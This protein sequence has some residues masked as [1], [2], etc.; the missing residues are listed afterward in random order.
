[1]NLPNPKYTIDL[2]YGS[3]EGKSQFKATSP[4][5][6][7]ISVLAA[8]NFEA[9]ERYRELVNEYEKN[10]PRKP[11]SVPTLLESQ[12]SIERLILVTRSRT[13]LAGLL[14]SHREITE[15]LGTYIQT[16]PKGKG[17]THDWK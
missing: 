3:F 16:Y 15:K 11:E 17:V 4:Q 14:A 5:Y 8:T 13:T 2:V 1:M 10:K 9:Y 6:P 7:Q 12:R